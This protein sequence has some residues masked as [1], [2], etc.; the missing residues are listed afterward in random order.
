MIGFDNDKLL[1]HA[2]LYNL[3]LITGQLRHTLKCTNL[4]GLC[5][6][7]NDRNV[8]RC[9]LI[10][11]LFRAIF[12]IFYYLLVFKVIIGA[13]FSF[14]SS[15]QV[16]EHNNSVAVYH[17]NYQLIQLN[18]TSTKLCE[19]KCCQDCRFYKEV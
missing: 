12:T 8:A 19:N 7:L 5:K 18:L 13:W 16:P 6:L 9:L 11:K 14:A 10:T 1:C 15:S 4:I 2:G 17:I 3:L